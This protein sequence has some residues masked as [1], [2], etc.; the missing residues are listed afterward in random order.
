MTT[1][2][3]TTR[4]QAI[5]ELG[6]R[7]RAANAPRP[8]GFMR[9]WTVVECQGFHALLAH[10]VI[11]VRRGIWLL[12]GHNGHLSSRTNQAQFMSTRPNLTL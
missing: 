10:G 3:I 6:D 7:P 4:K 9:S 12:P 8:V 1:N 2:T 11:L 5:A